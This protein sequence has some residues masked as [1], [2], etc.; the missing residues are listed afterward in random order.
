MGGHGVG[1]GGARAGDGVRIGPCR[2][3]PLL[4]ELGAD[5]VAID[6]RTHRTAWTLESVGSVSGSL[7]LPAHD[8]RLYVLRATSLRALPLR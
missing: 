1:E 4:G 7:Q 3:V 5:A 8:E 6:R 2:S